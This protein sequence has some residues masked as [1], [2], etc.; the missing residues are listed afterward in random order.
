MGPRSMDHHL[1]KRKRIR[2]CDSQLATL[3]PCF[4]CGA[5]YLQSVAAVPQL[6]LPP[7]QPARCIIC[8]KR[9]ESTEVVAAC[10]RGRGGAVLQPFTGSKNSEKERCPKNYIE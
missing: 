7:R 9:D 10:L 1:S 2:D 3:F 8:C 5:R 6:L 4:N